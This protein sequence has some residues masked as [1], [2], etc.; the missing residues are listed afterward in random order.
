MSFDENPAKRV[1]F[2]DLFVLLSE[3]PRKAMEERNE[4]EAN[5]EAFDCCFD[6]SLLDCIL[7][8]DDGFMAANRSILAWL[9]PE[10]KV[11]NLT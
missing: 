2:H 8:A 10:F 1:N 3:R 9:S 5:V 4:Q 6:P 7:R 11:R